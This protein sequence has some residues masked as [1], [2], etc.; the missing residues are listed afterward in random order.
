MASKKTPVKKTP[1]KPAPVPKAT[2]KPKPAGSK[3]GGA[4]PKK[5]KKKS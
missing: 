2:D 4:P 3:I 5:P 1:T